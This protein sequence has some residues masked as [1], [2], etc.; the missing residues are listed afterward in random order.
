VLLVRDYLVAHNLK[1][2]DGLKE[3]AAAEEDAAAA[4]AAGD[5]QGSSGSAPVPK[6]YQKHCAL[7]TRTSQR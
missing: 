4:G 3:L 5:R 6:T 1:L 7:C 2:P